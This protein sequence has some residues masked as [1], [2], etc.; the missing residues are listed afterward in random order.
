MPFKKLVD[1]CASVTVLKAS[2]KGLEKAVL[3][4]GI[5]N[6]S[7][8]LPQ[9]HAVGMVGPWRMHPRGP[10]ACAMFSPCP[11]ICVLQMWYWYPV[12]AKVLI[13]NLGSQ[14][15]QKLKGLDSKHI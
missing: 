15:K 12:E 2:G 11:G 9:W 4:I 3:L 10:E 8:E 7:S 6:D 14:K 1:C 13:K 5:G